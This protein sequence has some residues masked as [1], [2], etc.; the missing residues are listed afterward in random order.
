[1][2]RHGADECFAGLV[3]GERLAGAFVLGDKDSGGDKP[4][5]R[6]DVWL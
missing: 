1:M 5:L 2:M 3:D 4:P 6:F